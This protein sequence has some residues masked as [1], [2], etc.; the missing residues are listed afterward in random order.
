[1]IIP[2]VVLCLIQ[3]TLCSHERANC[4]ANFYDVYK[5]ALGKYDDVKMVA[6]YSPFE[7]S[8]A[9]FCSGQLFYSIYFQREIAKPTVIYMVMVGLLKIKQK[10]LVWLQRLIS[11][12]ATR[13]R[14]DIN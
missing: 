3:Q 13:H 2:L 4:I 9:S 1:M 5:D 14:I 6:E 7:V 12:D 10:G 11:P 8:D